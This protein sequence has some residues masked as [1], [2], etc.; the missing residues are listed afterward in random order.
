M[1]SSFTSSTIQHVFRKGNIAADWIAKMGV[2]LKTDLTFSHSSS[3]ELSCIIHA[4]YLGRTLARRTIEGLI[5]LNPFSKKKIIP[6]VKAKDIAASKF[7]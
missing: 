2:L 5:V 6:I 4:D 3:P 1:L 7:S